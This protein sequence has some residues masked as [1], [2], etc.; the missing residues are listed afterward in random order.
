MS[1]IDDQHE[2]VVLEAATR[3]EVD[4]LRSQISEIAA[5]QSRILSTLEGLLPPAP[6]PRKAPGPVQLKE[7]VTRFRSTIKDFT[8]FVSE[9]G[10]YFDQNKGRLITIKAKA[11]MFE[12][13][14]YDADP[15]ETEHLRELIANN[16]PH[17]F[18]DPMALPLQGVGVTE[19]VRTADQVNPVAE[20]SARL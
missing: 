9:G 19:G 7:G 12:N 1:D 10:S 15:E 17:V 3:D 13:G 16:D 4:E 11:I 5:G 2:E 18:E 14:V 20:L 6:K 8:T